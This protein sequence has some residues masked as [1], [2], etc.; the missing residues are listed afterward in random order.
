MIMMEEK[1]EREREVPIIIRRP[2]LRLA[3]LR[4]ETQR[5]GG[6][7][8]LKFFIAHT[9]VSIVV[10]ATRARLKSHKGHFV[11]HALSPFDPIS[12]IFCCF[13]ITVRCSAHNE[14]PQIC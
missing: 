5:D 7:E 14:F 9:I 2:T 12:G 10:G 11:A 8:I 6:N 13:Q 4:S 1:C 3:A